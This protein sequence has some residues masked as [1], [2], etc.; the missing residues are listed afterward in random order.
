MMRDVVWEPLL[1]G[2]S[3]GVFCCIACYPVLAPVFA[4]ENRSSGTTLRI[5]LRILLGR[6]A[7]Y[8]LFG[9]ATG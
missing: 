5:W 3:T 6:L 8:L 1:A 2:L 9:A 7:G 4:A